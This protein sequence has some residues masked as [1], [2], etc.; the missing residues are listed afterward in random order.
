MGS[1]FFGSFC[2]TYKYESG[3]N[4]IAFFNPPIPTGVLMAF[5]YGICN[6]IDFKIKYSNGRLSFLTDEKNG[7]N[8]QF[9]SAF[10]DITTSV[11]F[12]DRSTR[13]G[14]IDEKAPP[15]RGS[16]LL[17]LLLTFASAIF[18]FLA[19]LIAAGKRN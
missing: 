15:I 16:S 7:L 18:I 8:R 2:Y 19:Q 3:L 13:S 4:K 6:Y 11:M 1:L 17:L 10:F 5:L 12:S 14:N 9:L